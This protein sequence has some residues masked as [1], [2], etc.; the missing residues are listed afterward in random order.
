MK[1]KKLTVVFLS[2]LLCLIAYGVAPL[3]NAAEEKD[4]TGDT[5]STADTIAEQDTLAR[6]LPLIAQ[7]DSLTPDSLLDGRLSDSLALALMRQQAMASRTL[8][9]DSVLNS[10]NEDSILNMLALGQRLEL[11]PDSSKMDTTKRDTTKESKSALDFPVS[12][13]A[14]DSIT[15]DYILSRAI[16]YGDSKVDYEN[17]NLEADEISMSLDSSI[18]HA[19]GRPDST[20]E[21][22]GKPVFKQGSDTY[23]PDRISYNFKTRKAF[24]TNVYTQQGEGYLISEDSKRDSSGIMYLKG[25]KYTTCDDENPHFYLKLSRAKVR[26]GEKVVF[27]PAYLVVEDVPLPLAIPYGFFPF[28]ESYSSGLI[29][30]TYGDATSRAFCKRD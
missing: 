27:G 14:Q 25:G 12:Y 16:L 4:D 22:V 10:Y 6:Q 15:F 20:G 18:V 28:T 13:T 8:T 26:P 1:A 21:M 17:L 7:A 29:M 3:S 2:C 24:I 23:E 30:T 9:V 11:A 19:M 5:L